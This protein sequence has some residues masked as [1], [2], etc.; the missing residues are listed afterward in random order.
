MRGGCLDAKRAAMKQVPTSTPWS[1]H[2]E[3]GPGTTSAGLW[4]FMGRGPCTEKVPSAL[5]TEVDLRGPVTAQ[6]LTNPTSI[7]EDTG[8]IPGLA[9]WVKD[10]VLP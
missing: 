5:K 6:W 2:L 10:P 3:R 9:Q 8:L 4:P 7:H 1:S